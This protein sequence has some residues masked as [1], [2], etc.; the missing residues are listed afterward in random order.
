MFIGLLGVCIGAWLAPYLSSHYE[1]L[2]QKRSLKP[3]LIKSL[4]SYY[5][6]LNEKSEIVNTL[7]MD[8]RA[9]VLIDEKL[10]D[11]PI[12]KIDLEAKRQIL[13]DKINR[14][15]PQNDQIS[16][17]LTDAE[18]SIHSLV[19]QIGVY[20]K[21]DIYNEC[22]ALLKP[23]FNRIEKTPY[24]YDY[25]N[26]SLDEYNHL[27]GSMLQKQIISLGKELQKERSYLINALVNADF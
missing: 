15:N 8:E 20:Y 6:L 18:S 9:A 26:L 12:D 25:V 16:Y 1:K 5:K 10:R 17:G 2:R 14:K 21:I 11:Q 24:L 19:V 23:F 22:I 3:E 7:S 27:A 13:L 4:F